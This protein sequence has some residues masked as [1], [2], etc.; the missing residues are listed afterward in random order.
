MWFF[1]LH[2]PVLSQVSPNS[3]QP[4]LR[5]AQTRASPNSSQPKLEP[6]QT[7]VSPNPSQPKLEP[8]Q[9]RV[10]PNSSQPKL[11]SAQTKVSPNPSQPM[12]IQNIS[13]WRAERQRELRAIWAIQLTAARNALAKACPFNLGSLCV[14]VVLFGP[15][16]PGSWPGGAWVPWRAVP[17]SCWFSVC[18]L[19]SRILI[20]SF[21]SLFHLQNGHRPNSW[22]WLV[23]VLLTRYDW[24]G[25]MDHKAASGK[26]K[27]QRYE[28]EGWH[29][30]AP[31]QQNC[32]KAGIQR[33]LL[34]W[35]PCC[36]NCCRQCRLVI[37]IRSH[38]GSSHLGLRLKH[39]LNSSLL[40]GSVV[41]C[42]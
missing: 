9:T 30:C 28:H 29:E 39:C 21:V 38:F 1:L 15:V 7:R 24:P 36:G 5:S 2:A 11:K 25:R 22:R 40:L 27:R 32:P 23:F 41:A 13:R 8:A 16:S 33:Q 6:A 18:F 17:W 26:K 12:W 20:L 34:Q 10:S 19:W 14:G 3:S 42:V 37:P 31:C 35:S 4:K